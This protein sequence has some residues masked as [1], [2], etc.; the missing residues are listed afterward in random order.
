M[1]IFL[2]KMLRTTVNRLG[3]TT[4]NDHVNLNK[5]VKYECGTRPYV[6]LGEKED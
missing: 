5:A 2:G 4:S 3:V 1:V 6:Y